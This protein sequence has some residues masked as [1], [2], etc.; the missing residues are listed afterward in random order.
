M[1]GTYLAKPFVGMGALGNGQGYRFLASDGPVFDF[2]AAGFFGSGGGK[3]LPG[4]V[5]GIGAT[6]DGNGYWL[7]VVERFIRI[8]KW[9]SRVVGFGCIS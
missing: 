8:E 3:S 7:V 1:G 5:V 4:P 9:R 2:G 6:A